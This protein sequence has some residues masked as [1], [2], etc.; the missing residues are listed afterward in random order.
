[1]D[2]E[3]ESF[4]QVEVKGTKYGMKIRDGVYLPNG[5]KNLSNSK[6]F[7]LRDDDIFISSFP[8][9]GT[10]WTNE[11]VWLIIHNLDFESSQKNLD[12]KFIWLDPGVSTKIIDDA[13]SPRLFK[14]HLPLQ[15]LPLEI[16]SENIKKIYVLRNPKDMLVST[17][18]FYRK[19]VKDEFTGE[20]EDLV[21]IF[22]EGKTWYGPWW[23]HVDSFVTL[24]NTF[25]VIY[26]NLIKKPNETIK[27]LGEFLGKNLNESEIEFLIESTSF[28]KMKEAEKTFKDDSR[29]SKIF[30][31]DLI[32]FRKGEIGDWKNYFDEVMS[33]R[34]EAVVEKNLKFKVNFIY[35]S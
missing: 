28:K 10:T 1:M 27:S 12:K 16:K 4:D 23:S 34:I 9:S 18:H 6:C 26:E 14:N 13:D 8:K 2:A 19:L 25:L 22:E 11:L 35:D 21:D 29:H 7:K 3:V 31:S 33:K 17:F 20:F 30:K 15:F 24:P 32:F 5:I